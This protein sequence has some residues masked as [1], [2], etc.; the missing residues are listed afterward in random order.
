MKVETIKDGLIVI[1]T[2]AALLGGATKF[3]GNV[4]EVPRH[5]RQ[6]KRLGRRVTAVESM[7]RFLVEDVEKRTSKKYIAPVIR[8]DEGDADEARDAD[9]N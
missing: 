4:N 6:I 5:E 3:L 2:G 7:T 8:D 1:A 9:P